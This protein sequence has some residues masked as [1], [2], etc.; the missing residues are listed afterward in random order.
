MKYIFRTT[1]QVPIRSRLD[2]VTVLKHHDPLRAR[3]RRQPMR[4][5][6]ARR[7]AT[8]QDLVDRVV[9]AVLRRCIER[10]CRLVERENGRL[11][12]QRAGDREPLAL[13]TT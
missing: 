1:H 6:K 7:L 8:T 12:Q 4:D 5:D 10:A 13:P 2:D 3:D 11:A 9:D